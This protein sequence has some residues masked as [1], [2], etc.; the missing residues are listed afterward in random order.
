MGLVLCAVVCGCVG[1]VVASVI[2]LVMVVL[3]LL[4]V[5]VVVGGCRASTE[6]PVLILLFVV[7]DVGFVIFGGGTGGGVCAPGGIV[8]AGIIVAG[9]FVGVR[10]LID[11]NLRTLVLSLLP[12][13]SCSVVWFCLGVG[14]SVFVFVSGVVV[15]VCFASV[16]LSRGGSFGVVVIPI[17]WNAINALYVFFVVF[18]F[19]G[20]VV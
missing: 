13:S 9:I 12:S 3:C 8:G 10:V 20:L 4:E 18:L 6:A 2:L 19:L 16:V 14:T 1:G 11:R 17:D 7:C 5:V 15:V